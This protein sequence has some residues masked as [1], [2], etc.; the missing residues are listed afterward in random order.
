[1]SQK[2]DSK[3]SDINRM[4]LQIAVIENQRKFG[5]VN[6]NNVNRGTV[7]RGITVNLYYL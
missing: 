7:N 6:R 2:G 4:T 1:M 3:K 5:H